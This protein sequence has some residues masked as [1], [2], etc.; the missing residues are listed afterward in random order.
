MYF[1]ASNG[2]KKALVI[3]ASECKVTTS[4]DETVVSLLSIGW[5]VTCVVITRLELDEFKLEI[6]FL[7]NLVNKEASLIFEI[8]GTFTLNAPDV[9]PAPTGII[10]PSFTPETSS[11][12]TKVRVLPLLLILDTR[13]NT[14]SVNPPW[15]YDITESVVIPTFPANFRPGIV[16]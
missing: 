2:S 12:L 14:G 10:S 1:S 11:V 16:P 8:K 7:G 9:D 5:L 4:F 3:P 6:F 15:V 13:L